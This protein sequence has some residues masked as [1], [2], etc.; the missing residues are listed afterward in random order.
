MLLTE[1]NGE[2]LFEIP[3]DIAAGDTLALHL[4]VTVAE[5]KSPSA[6]VE[7]LNANGSVLTSAKVNVDAGNIYSAKTV[8]VPEGAVYFRF[9]ITFG[10]NQTYN[11]VLFPVLVKGTTSVINLQTFEDGAVTVET[12]N[13]TLCICS[14]PYESK[15]EYALEL[16]KYIDAQS[17]GNT[18]AA[19]D[20]KTMSF[21][22]PEMFGAWS[23]GVHDDTA[24]VQESVDYA[25]ANKVKVIA[26]GRYMTSQPI[27]MVGN[28]QSVDIREIHYSGDDSAVTVTGSYNSVRIG[29]I[30]ANKGVGLRNIADGA[31]C[32]QNVYHIGRI[33]SG[34][35]AIENMVVAHSSI[36]NSFTFGALHCGEGYA[37]IYNSPDEGTGHTSTYWCNNNNFTGG[38]LSGG[39]WGVYNARAQDTYM[40]CMFEDIDN[41]V[42]QSGHGRVRI[43]SPRY[44]EVYTHSVDKTQSNRPIIDGKGIVIKLESPYDIVPVDT[45]SAFAFDIAAASS[46]IFTTNIDISGVPVSLTKESGEVFPITKVGH[47][48]K[49]DIELY[50]RGGFLISK[51]FLILGNHILI[52]E[53]ALKMT[54]NITTADVGYVGDYRTVDNDEEFFIYD[55]FVVDDADCEYTLPPSYDAMAFDKFVVKQNDNANCVFKDWRGTPIFNGSEYGSGEYEVAAR[56]KPGH[57]TDL[58]DNRYQIWEIRRISD[59][60]LVDTMPHETNV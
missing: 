30:D 42:H 33:V 51:Y 26:G 44:V 16:K 28:Y 20:M 55:R 2:K 58:F 53:P 40:T 56:I 13:E 54:K 45:E 4:F 10:T 57:E 48:H 17:E 59:R 11:S 18:G 22:T 43:I 25:I 36:C 9:S 34:K 12:E 47:F 29:F 60:S 19:L 1:Q 7:L 27:R 15:V 41:C 39:K 46:T 24:A 5:T 3:P 23:D 6:F 37:C 50:D 8:T 38:R 35:N 31:A 49:I 14:A 21:V 52:Q 32:R